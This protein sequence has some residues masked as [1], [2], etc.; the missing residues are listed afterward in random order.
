MKKTL[1]LSILTLLAIGACNTDEDDIMPTPATPQT[2]TTTPADTLSGVPTISIETTNQQAISNKT[3][4][5]A[6]HISI[7]GKGVYDN[8]ES[9]ETDSIRGR[10]N[11]TWLWY[12]KKPYKIK[13]ST[14]AGLLGMKAGKK[15]VLLANYRDPTALMNAV[16]FD[17]ARYMGM[18]YVNTN[19]FV[20]LTLNG[21]Y[22]GLY[23]LTEQIE[24]G[25][26]RVAIAKNGGTLISLDLDDGPELSPNNNNF[27][28]EVFNSSYSWYGLPVCVKYPKEPTPQQL[29]TIKKEFAQIENCISELDYEALQQILDVKSMFSFLIIQEI[30]RN[31]ELVTPR[32]MYMYRDSADVWHFGPVWD[33][34][35]GYAFDWGNNHGYFGSQSWLMGTNSSFDIPE[36]FDGMFQND[37]FRTDY[38][39]YWQEVKEPMLNYILSHISNYQNTCADA[40]L[41]DRDRWPIGR[42]YQDEI[43]RLRNWLRTR[44]SNY[45]GFE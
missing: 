31:V 10:G 14:K 34:D 1:I 28:S 19:R 44:F 43:R 3:D 27:Y 22:I 37:D 35:G 17:M 36:F 9:V 41:R 26:G 20:E 11:S 32:S 25:S 24:Q 30:T 42:T 40:M 13:L 21:E 7:D 39:N 29:K 5:I 8:Y 16:A 4:Y 33:F 12:D 2:T 45:N 18:Q 23:Q 15:Y 38:K 6:C